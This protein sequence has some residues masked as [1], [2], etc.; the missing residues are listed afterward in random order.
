MHHI[1][2]TQDC[3]FKELDL[4]KFDNIHRYEVGKLMHN[5]VNSNLRVCLSDLFVRTAHL[6]MCST[7]RVYPSICLQIVKYTKH[8][9]VYRTSGLEFIYNDI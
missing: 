6:H 2:A 5:F 7:K 4:F 9:I 3:M 1:T 8:Y